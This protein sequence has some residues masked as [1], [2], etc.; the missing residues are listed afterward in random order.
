MKKNTILTYIFALSSLVVN[1]QEKPVN[2]DWE[3]P[4]VFEINREAARAA[5][6]P[7]ADESS[8]IAD[9]YTRSPW[10]LAL[11]GQ[12]K[13]NWSPT[14]DE[15]PKDF[16]KTDFNTTNWKEIAVPSNWELM[17]YGIPIYTNIT[18]PFVKN[19]P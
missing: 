17:G 10:F 5:F 8:A 11:D 9:E 16:F 4:A 3:N 14:P 6:L 15:R 2:N 13:F 7:Y 1:A 12:W 18:Y 19:P